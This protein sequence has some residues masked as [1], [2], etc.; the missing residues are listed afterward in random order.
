MHNISGSKYSSNDTHE[1][2][3]NFARVLRLQFGGSLAKTFSHQNSLDN[4]EPSNLTNSRKHELDKL[5]SG[6]F[7]N[8]FMDTNLLFEDTDSV[9]EQ[10]DNCTAG[11]PV[12]KESVL[13]VSQW[14]LLPVDIQFQVCAALSRP[15]YIFCATQQF[16]SKRSSKS[17]IIITFINTTLRLKMLSINLSRR[18]FVHIRVTLITVC[19]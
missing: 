7:L 2:L 6:L 3:K 15:A 13:P 14:L 11:K 12:S 16:D 1:I 4:Q 17:S 10:H 9:Q 8:I 5:I 19:V 18:T